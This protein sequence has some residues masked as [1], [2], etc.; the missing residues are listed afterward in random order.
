MK[1]TLKWFLATVAVVLVGYPALDPV[2]PIMITVAMFAVMALPLG[3]VIG[4]RVQMR[5]A[6]SVGWGMAIA[7]T[8]GLLVAFRTDARAATLGIMV[9]IPF[10]ATMF[11][12][13]YS[14][15]E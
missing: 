8:V 15:R 4:S 3:V 1:F 13:T 11:G 7:G 2:H 5:Y 14:A 12:L 9:A 10:Y 6:T